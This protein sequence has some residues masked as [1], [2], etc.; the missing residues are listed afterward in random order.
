MAKLKELWKQVMDSLWLVPGLLTVSAVVLAV[1]LMRVDSMLVGGELARDMWWLFGGTAQG[2]REVLSVIAASIITV[3]GVVFSITIVALQLASTQLSPRVLRS[4]MADR[5][6]QVVLGVFIGTFTYALLVLRAVR[7]PGEEIDGFMPSASITGAVVLMLVS[8]G[9]LIFFIHH[10][11]RAIQAGALVDRVTRE[12]H[13]VIRRLFRPLGEESDERPADVIPPEAPA[14]VRVR[15]AGYILR[16]DEQDA[17]A[18]AAGHAPPLTVGMERKVGDFVLPGEPLFSVWPAAALDD[19]L[20][21]GLRENVVLGPE[22]TPHQD[23]AY[24]IVELVDIA[25]K[26]LS[27]GINDPNTAVVV[28]DRLSELYHALAQR[29][30]GPVVRRQ[31][32]GSVMI[33]AH[34]DFDTLLHDGIDPIRHFG[35][36]TP[37]VALHLID[38]LSGLAARLEGEPRAA[39]ARCIADVARQAA[40]SEADAADRERVRRAAEAA[41]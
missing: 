11:A 33:L 19:D 36:G 25:V 26:A 39:V 20:A 3:T 23:V 10:V 28:I 12:T 37:L 1:L 2:G 4:F 35:A 15:E 18:E 17:A 6:T 38:A 9:F 32:D 14:V 31:E 22:R 16:I 21:D 8:I 7:Q 29:A 40:A 13:E 34:P 41:L 30:L 24:G 5:P 27:P